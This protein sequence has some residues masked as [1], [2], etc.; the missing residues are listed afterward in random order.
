VH[1]NPPHFPNTYTLSHDVPLPERGLMTCM[2]MRKFYLLCMRSEFAPSDR[3]M[4][5]DSRRDSADISAT[6]CCIPHFCNNV[7]HPCRNLIP[8]STFYKNP[9]MKQFTASLLS[10]QIG[11]LKEDQLVKIEQNTSPTFLPFRIVLQTK[12]LLLPLAY[13]R[14]HLFFQ[15]SKKH[16]WELLE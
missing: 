15:T 5:R 12:S 14:P 10:R 3:H 6:T 8:T 13:E 4:K 7:L 11:P 1:Q 9:R 2:H 16:V